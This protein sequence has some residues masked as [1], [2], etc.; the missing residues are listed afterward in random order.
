MAKQKKLMIVEDSL[1]QARV[2]A[3]HLSREIDVVIA[4]DGSQALRL[5]AVGTPD[6]IILDINLPKLN[7]IQVCR[8]LKRDPETANIPII[9][10]TAT[11]NPEQMKEG[12]AAGADKYLLKGEHAT[13]ELLDIL[14]AY[15]L[16]DDPVN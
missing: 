5:V 9:M 13:E 7:G 4:T 2:L 12:L 8:R 6:L 1:T 15:K 10:I 14:R 11:T 16:L 3:A